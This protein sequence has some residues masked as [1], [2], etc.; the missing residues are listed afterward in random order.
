MKIIKKL[1][2]SNMIIKP[3]YLLGLIY[4]FLALL[5]SRSF[6]GVYFLNYRIGE[7]VML[8]SAISLVYF[9][10]LPFSSNELV[11][12]LRIINIGLFMIFGINLFL[13][14]SSIFN[15]YSFKTSTYIWSLGFFL[16]GIFG[17]KFEIDKKLFLLFIGILAVVYS[18]AIYEFPLWIQDL[19]LNYSD[20][21]E[22]HKA[23]D[24]VLMLIIFSTYF[25]SFLDHNFSSLSGHSVLY[26]I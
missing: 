18:T 14:N 21:Y 8:I 6:V 9:T 19:F 22:P 11:R 1:F 2:Q 20:K 16:I 5:F 7:L 25:K 24:I 10:F 13:S 4:S 15:T 26:L 23:A 17:N 12:R 3:L